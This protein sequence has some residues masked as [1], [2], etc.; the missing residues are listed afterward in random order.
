M[1]IVGKKLN[2]EVLRITEIGLFLDSID[3]KHNGILLPRKYVPNGVE[4]G[5]FMDV[6]IYKDSEDRIIATR[7]EPY[8]NIG[9]F[10]YLTVNKVESFGAFLDWGIPKD[11]FVPISQQLTPM[12]DKEIY[13]VYAYLDN[14]TNRIAATSKV[15]KHIKNEAKELEI[16]QQISLLICDKTE[17]GVRVIVNN[18]FWGLIFHNEIFQEITQGQKTIGYVK[19]IREDDQKID[20]TLKKRG[21]EELKDARS[22]ILE[23]L[24]DNNGFLPVHDKTAPKY[25]YEKLE[26]S[27]KVFKKAIGNLYKERM[28]D[29]KKNGIY[30]LIVK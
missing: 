18:T 12:I 26:M 10:A 6:F 23:A 19:K 3:R 5:D 17:L 20:I 16:G 14:Q 4:V 8:I 29:I 27:K 30:L 24:H 21:V 9:E 13:L 15:H 22:Q 1:S 11:L 25:I 28:I 2:L 7:L